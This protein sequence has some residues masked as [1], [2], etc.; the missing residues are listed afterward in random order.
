MAMNTAKQRYEQIDVVSKQEA[1]LAF[2][3][4]HHN[5][6]D[7]IVNGTQSVIE[8]L[9]I[10]NLVPHSFRI[11]MVAQLHYPLENHV[12]TMFASDE[13]MPRITIN[14]GQS[15]KSRWTSR[16]W[17]SGRQELQD[18]IFIDF[19]NIKLD[20]KDAH[21]TIVDSIIIN[22]LMKSSISSCDNNLSLSNNTAASVYVQSFDIESGEM[23][24]YGEGKLAAKFI[25]KTIGS[26]LVIQTKEVRDF[27]FVPALVTALCYIHD[28]FSAHVKLAFNESL[29]PEIVGLNE[30]TLTH[31]DKKYTVKRAGNLFKFET[32]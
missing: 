8:H 25:T 13:N 29:H 26:T 10:S 31:G 32:K 30:K 19:C 5:L 15:L 1:V 17:N 6:L 9:G 24:V 4:R 2:E 21:D 27:N 16:L 11:N 23:I 22:L 20:D 18:E 14:L 12:Y 7:D 28:N 3:D